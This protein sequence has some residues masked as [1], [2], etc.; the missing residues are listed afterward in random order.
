MK[1]L[2]PVC[3]RPFNSSGYHR[4][5]NFDDPVE[6]LAPPSAARD[7]RRAAEEEPQ[8]PAAKEA[9]PKQDDVQLRLPFGRDGENG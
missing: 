4:S 2:C 6:F 1:Q 8:S 5:P 7:S 3:G 9:K